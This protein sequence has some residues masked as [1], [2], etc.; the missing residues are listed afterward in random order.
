[1][2]GKVLK[3]QEAEQLGIVNKVVAADDLM[4]EALRWAGRLAAGPGYTLKMDKSCYVLLCLTISTS[5][6]NWKACIKC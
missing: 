3:S 1:M 2:L 5:R 4:D 6:L